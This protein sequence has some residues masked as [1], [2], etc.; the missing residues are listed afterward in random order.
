V[1]ALTAWAMPIEGTLPCSLCYLR[2]GIATMEYSGDK[3]VCRDCL[4]GQAES[5]M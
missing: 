3:L 4:K 2:V 5:A 1:I